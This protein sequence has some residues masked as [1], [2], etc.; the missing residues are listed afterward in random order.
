MRSLPVSLG[1]YVVVWPEVAVQAF[2]SPIY[3]SPF[4]GEAR[5]PSC[6]QFA[7]IYGADGTVSGEESNYLD[8][9]ISSTLPRDVVESVSNT[10][11]MP[12]LI[13][14][15]CAFAPPPHNSLQPQKVES[16]RLVSLESTKLEIAVAVPSDGGLVQ[17]LVPMVF[18]TPCDTAASCDE[19]ENTLR[20][21]IQQ[22]DAMAMER[23]G[24]YEMDEDSYEELADQKRIMQAL[25]EEPLGDLPEWWTFTNLNLS[26]QEECK[27]MK[28]LLNEDDF[29]TDLHALCRVHGASDNN[30]LQAGV[31][32][33]GPSGMFLRAQV[34]KPTTN[35]DLINVAIPFPGEATT[36]DDLR[37]AVLDVVESVELVDSPST[38]PL[39][40]PEAAEEGGSEAITMEAEEKAEEST[41]KPLG[42]KTVLGAVDKSE[43]L[44]AKESPTTKDITLARQQPK[45]LEA[46]ARLAAKYASIEDLSERAYVILKDLYMI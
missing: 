34:E 42:D 18:P 35:R 2:L 5:Y 13:R 4:V 33:I 38:E 8:P 28:A 19:V 16:A 14:L 29:A 21:I 44:E 37:T 26:L 41:P 46:E 32:A 23:I 15:G 7:L 11:A 17:V 20:E 43:G 22:M 30:I 31:A 24:D 9:V 45:A 6:P 1:I 10:L 3:A 12:L 36:G 39:S 27:S 40:L 25:K